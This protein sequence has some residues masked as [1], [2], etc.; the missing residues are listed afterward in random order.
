[1]A[2][3]P[4]LQFHHHK[5]EPL[6]GIDRRKSNLLLIPFSILNCFLKILCL[7]ALILGGHS[8][9]YSQGSQINLLLND[10]SKSKHDSTTTR[11]LLNLGN[12]YLDFKA[13]STEYFANKAI[14]IAQRHD[15]FASIGQGYNSIGIGYLNQAK[16]LRA[17]DFFHLAY[18]Y[19]IKAGDKEGQAKMLNNLGVIYSQTENYPKA[20][21]NFVKAY[22]LGVEIENPIQ[23]SYALHNLAAD[24]SEINE[25]DKA[26]IYA[27]KLESLNKQYPTSLSANGVL[28]DIFFKLNKLD[29]AS[30]YMQ[31]LLIGIKKENDMYYWA[32]SHLTHAEILLKS[33]KISEA[34]REINKVEGDIEENNFS[35]LKVSMYKLKS[36]Y[37]DA[38]QD[39][40]KALTNFK[41]YSELKD[42]LAS[43]NKQNFIHEVS[44]RYET[45][46]M[47][48]QL[49]E[50]SQVIKNNRIMVISTLAV[51]ISLLFGLF[52]VIYSLRKNKKLGRL[53]ELKNE[54]INAQRHKIISSINY[55][56]RIQQSALP[57]EYEFNKLFLD[58][59][60]YFKPKDIIS[61]DF[62]A[63]QVIDQKIYIA[64][65]DCTGHG[66]PGAFMSLIANAKL[67]KILNELGERDPGKILNLMHD[68]IQ[69]ALNQNENG[70]HTQDGLEMSIC[71][72]DREK[73]EI[74]FSGAGSPII[75]CSNGQCNE[76]KG[77][78][79]GLGGSEIM[80][81]AH[82]LNFKTSYINYH[83]NDFLFLFSDGIADQLG[84]PDRK[85]LNKT[86]FNNLLSEISINKFDS[87]KNHCES[88]LQNWKIA[89][90]QTDDMML[91][92]I[93][94]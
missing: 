13:D 42:S 57:K 61:G 22:D 15:D 23:T 62:Y 29:S 56:Q 94:L 87:A 39:F 72:I 63:Y 9:S 37:F 83:E 40:K 81:G 88:Y 51:A 38:T 54:E 5:N 86:K 53:L 80:L 64:A 50:Q 92:G 58:S 93:R 30:Y 73:K 8:V 25:T 28:A 68:E 34:N 45:D 41:N 89:E 91:I 75:L 18:E 3:P 71:A 32:A 7:S 24:Y 65:V 47:E 60:I 70:D 16:T 55:A 66:V 31:Q 43:D 27:Y 21:E 1:M 46:R 33:G 49:E 2:H 35:D 79:H 44:A 26:L 76:Y 67:N 59:F 17:L 48:E 69:R 90:P 6:S 78:Y 52:S 11:I 77:S 4:D 84:G 82:V 12:L 20:I 74:A 85:K 19:Y 36:E 14:E 10:L